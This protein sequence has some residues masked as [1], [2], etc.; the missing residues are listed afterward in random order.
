MWIV[1]GGG[2]DNQQLW[3]IRKDTINA[4][5]LQSPIICINSF[6]AKSQK[7]PQAGI[8]KTFYDLHELLKH[9]NVALPFLMRCFKIH[10]KNKVM[11]TS[12]GQ[13]WG[14]ENRKS[15]SR[16]QTCAINVCE[17]VR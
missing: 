3:R 8:K 12:C 2:I 13:E 17:H 10:I 7:P 15:S 11:E 14:Q 5:D 6:F 9:E 1:D 4:N 16:T